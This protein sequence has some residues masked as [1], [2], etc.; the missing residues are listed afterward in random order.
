MTCGGATTRLIRPSPK[1]GVFWS[2]ETGAA[3]DESERDAIV[4]LVAA[5]VACGLYEGGT[6]RPEG[7]ETVRSRFRGLPAG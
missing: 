1:K 6:L 7:V 3:A 4:R 2:H 5:T